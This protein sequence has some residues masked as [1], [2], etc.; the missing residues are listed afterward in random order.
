MNHHLKFFL[1]LSLLWLS[2]C[3]V[4]VPDNPSQPD[5]P[6]RGP[7]TQPGTAMGI[8][9]PKQ[10]DLYDGRFIISGGPHLPGR[11]AERREPVGPYGQ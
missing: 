9:A 4:T 10:H 11:H 8:Y 7:R 6:E 3:N 1:P 2:A 5:P